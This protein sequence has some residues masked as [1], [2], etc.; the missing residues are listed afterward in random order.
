MI[1]H[2]LG[3]IF[4]ILLVVSVPVLLFSVVLSLVAIS[5]IIEGIEAVMKM[6]NDR[7]W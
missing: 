7:R 3:M 2:I 1:G 4:W 6:W 5:L